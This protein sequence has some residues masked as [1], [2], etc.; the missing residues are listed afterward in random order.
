MEGESEEGFETV[1]SRMLECVDRHDRGRCALALLLEHTESLAGHFYGIE[2]DGSV[3]LLATLPDEPE[4]H[5]LTA[6][7]TEYVRAEAES[8]QTS[9]T[10][11]ASV[12]TDADEG[13]AASALGTRYKDERGRSF[14]ATV[15][16]AQTPHETRLVAVLVL[17]V[18]QGPRTVAPKELLAELARQL[19][20]HGDAQGIPG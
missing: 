9:A 14:E 19:Y 3:T 10:A 20:A 8:S 7:L 12:S 1:E 15:L 18:G 16:A 2:G 5:D 11:T 13:D 4:D 17:Q 6:W